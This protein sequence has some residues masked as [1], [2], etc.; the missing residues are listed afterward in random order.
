MK[1]PVPPGVNQDGPCSCGGQNGEK[2][3]DKTALYHTLPEGKRANGESGYKGLVEKAINTQKKQSKELKKFLGRAKN[4]QETL[5]IRLKLFTSLYH[6]FHHGRSTQNKMDF[7]KLCV[8]AV[9]VIVQ[10]DM[11]N[12]SPIFDL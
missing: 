8:E 7:H 11:D 9:C 3:L 12:G 1:G 4:R 10:Y 6:R 5:H 2:D